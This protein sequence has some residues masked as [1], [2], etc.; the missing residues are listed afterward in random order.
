MA[1]GLDE[2]RRAEAA[3]L[4]ERLTVILKPLA[5]RDPSLVRDLVASADLSECPQPDEEVHGG[6]CDGLVEGPA[7]H[8]P[9]RPPGE[10]RFL[11]GRLENGREDGE[12]VKRQGG[13]HGARGTEHSSCQATRPVC[14]LRV[15]TRMSG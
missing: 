3:H 1:R 5:R 7:S 13:P 2:A 4:L 9:E 11:E 8:E 14:K 15:S 10:D 12:V 6:N